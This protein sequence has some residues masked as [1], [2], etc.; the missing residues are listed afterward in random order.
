MELPPPFLFVHC[1]A[2][3]LTAVP[4]ECPPI[5]QISY[6]SA[7]YH[8]T[9]RLLLV[10]SWKDWHLS[11][12]LIVF[13]ALRPTPSLFDP[14]IPSLL[15]TSIS[16][17]RTTGTTVDSRH[18]CFYFGAER[19]PQGQK[20]HPPYVRFPVRTTCASSAPLPGLLSRASV[21]VPSSQHSTPAYRVCFRP[22][23]N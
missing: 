20:R 19:R 4:W 16:A 18:P 8:G 13:V 12:L 9:S 17:L 7:I 10:V 1:A 5:P 3:P 15:P 21:I 23:T 22:N 14:L 2:R 6:I 11:L